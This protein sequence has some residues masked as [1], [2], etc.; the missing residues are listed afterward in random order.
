MDKTSKAIIAVISKDLCKV[1]SNMGIITSSIYL[2]QF[3]SIMKEHKTNIE[4]LKII[5]PDFIE[6]FSVLCYLRSCD[7]IKMEHVK[8][9]LIY[10]WENPYFD[11]CDYFLSTQILETVDD[12]I[13]WDLICK[14][15]DENPKIVEQVKGGKPQVAGS[16]I[17][18]LKKDIG[19]KF[20][21]SIAMPMIHKRIN[22]L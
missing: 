16:I 6:L 4:E 1:P 22:E 3:T 11:I 20:D 10:G 15:L 5:R 21:A 13:V 9:L 7:I 18:K 14:H 8:N 12:S 17:G 2:N 19:D